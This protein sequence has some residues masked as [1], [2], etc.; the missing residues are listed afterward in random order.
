MAI[1]NHLHPES[2]LMDGP[3]MTATLFR[4]Q[5]YSDLKN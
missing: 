3:M 2:T 4:L 1:H 5:Y